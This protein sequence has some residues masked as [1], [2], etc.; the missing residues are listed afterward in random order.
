[1]ALSDERPHHRCGIRRITNDHRAHGT[2][3]SLHEP[4]E[5]RVVDE[6]STASTAVLTR[7]V[8]DPTR[9]GGGD[10]VEVGVGED[11]VGALATEF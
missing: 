11:D 8:E 3:E 6:D 7:V 2:F 9:C 4:L 1:M 5:D 10:F